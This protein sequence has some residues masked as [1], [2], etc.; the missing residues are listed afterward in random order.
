MGRVT[1]FQRIRVPVGFVFAAV[2]LYFAQPRLPSSYAGIALAATGLALRIWASGY[3]KKGRELATNGPYVWSRNP[4]YFGSFLLGLG[5]S[6]ASGRLL[7]LALFVILFFAIYFPVMKNEEEELLRNFGDRYTL[8]R[9]SVPLFVPH[10]RN[11]ALFPA[12]Q[13][14]FRWRRVI[15]NGEYHTVAGFL[16]LTVFVLVKTP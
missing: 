12:T 9:Q 14:N 15:L 3:L 6:L 11:H 4:L 5:F 8:Y 10:F 2:F 7:L 16:L 1:L 13:V